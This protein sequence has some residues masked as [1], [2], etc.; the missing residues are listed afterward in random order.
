M[1]KDKNSIYPSKIEKLL[2]QCKFVIFVLK[3][4]IRNYLKYIVIGIFFIIG[5][6]L[7]WKGITYFVPPEIKKPQYKN[8]KGTSILI[9]K[10][11]S[12][13]VVLDSLE[14]KDII[15]NR[16]WA[17]IIMKVFGF[18]KRI[19]AGLFFLPDTLNTY[20]TLYYLTKAPQQLVKITIPEG[21]TYKRIA[22]LFSEKFPLKKERFLQLCTD[23]LFLKKLG[24]NAST[25]EGYLHPETYY[26]PFN[27]VSEEVLKKLVHEQ[28]KIFEIDSIK[29]RLQELGWSKHQ[30]L[31]MAS[32]VEGEAIFDEEKPLIA[33]VYWNRLR[34]GWRLQADPTIQYLISDGPRRLTYKDLKIDSPYNT[35]MYK[36]LPPGPINNPGTAS[37]L[38][39]LF[40]AQTT[41][42]YF[43]AK[44]DGKHH[45]SS[46]L[47]EHNNWK[48]KFNRIRKKVYGY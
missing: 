42:Y 22:L 34:K 20:Q 1:F 35:Y 48:R 2:A 40:P 25:I 13:K 12:S 17:R 10:G 33:S 5:I 46:T 9:P 29:K 28:L 24:V 43:V 32:I 23:T 38:A 27:V 37:I 39:V 44:G 15:Q 26:F 41:Y 16:F 3:V 36:G 18:D 31:T 45:F 6:A 8:V 11:T 14:Q 47:R 21:L 4:M 7:F 30:I 19:K